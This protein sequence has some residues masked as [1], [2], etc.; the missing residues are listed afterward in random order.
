MYAV[1]GEHPHR[2]HCIAFLE[3]V[4]RGFAPA[5]I[6]AEVLQE[7]LH[8]YKSIGRWPQGLQAYD[9]ARVLFPDALVITTEVMDVARNLMESHNHLGARDAVHA[10]VVRVYGL[11]SI[12]SYDKDFDK[13]PGLKRVEPRKVI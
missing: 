9:D 4:L 11:E 5:V 7:I 6:D 10:A 2:K 1:G 13:I 3:K 8:R 12:C